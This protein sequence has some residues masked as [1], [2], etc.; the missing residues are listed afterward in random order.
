M[1]SLLEWEFKD[2]YTQKCSPILIQG[3]ISHLILL[4]T[5]TPCSLY[6]D[7]YWNQENSRAYTIL[8]VLIH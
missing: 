8:F 4:T 2:V 7:Y 3:P 6:F 1:C 5:F